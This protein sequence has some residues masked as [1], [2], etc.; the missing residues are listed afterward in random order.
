MEKLK[1]MSAADIARLVNGKEIS[2]L[3]VIE[4]FIERITLRNKSIN[5]FVYTDFDYALK[6]AEK[7]EKRILKGEYI[8]PFAGVPFALKDFL[9]SKKGWNNSH[10]GVKS[11]IAKDSVNSQFCIALESAGG[12]AIGKTNAPAFGFR[13]TCDNK[14]YGPTSTPFNTLYNSGGSS[15]GSAAAVAD[16]LVPIAEG[17]DGGGSIRIPA[18]WCNCFGFKPT[19]GLVPEIK[20]PD[21]WSATHPYCVDG[22]IT[23]TVEDSEILFS[24]MASYNP[25]DPLC[26]PIKTNSSITSLK[27]LKIGYTSNFG[28][29]SVE[30]EVADITEKAA[31]EFQKLGA[32]VEFLDINLGYSAEELSNMW[33]RSISVDTA[34]DLQL[35]RKS[36]F[37]LVKDHREELPEEFIYWNEIAAKS[38]VIDL[39]NFNKM[40]TAVYD[41]FEDAFESYD[42]IVSPTTACL[43][44]LNANDGN[45][46]GPQSINGIKTEPLIGFCETFLAN[47]SGHPAASVP[48]G[49]SKN[50]LPVGM[51]IIG[52]KFHDCD[53]FA[54]A[55]AFESLK[56]W[57]KYYD[58]PL[59]RK[60]N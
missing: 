5:A 13:G 1:K 53:I 48:A 14:L 37:D 58:I 45:T 41:A 51:Q 47:F 60:T 18:A 4:Y 20:R 57:Q 31:F 42:I 22:G 8:G 28:V 10:G 15:G 34:I 19:V 56:P 3:E 17:T 49:L 36:G 6:E 55:K 16:G 33:C 11:L 50:N 52:K 2:P 27:G 23:K 26:V 25:R 35:Q 9:P 29:F 44:V 54:V 30:K 43:P 21:A 38:G 7:L 40:R 39:Y 46:K 24:L 32:D 12:I 59:N